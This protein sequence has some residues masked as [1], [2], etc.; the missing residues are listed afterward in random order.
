MALDF[1]SNPVNGQT[2]GN[3]YYDSD[4]GIWRSLYRPTVP[5]ILESPTINNA[6]ITTT[7]TNATT[8][9][10]TVKGAS[11]QSS[12]LQEWKNSSGT[13]LTSISSSGDLTATN[14]TITNLILNRTNSVEEGG[15]INFNRASDN[16]NHW[17]IDVFGSTSTPSLRF[18][19]STQTNMQ[20]D[21][22]GRVT[23]PFQPA[24]YAQP[25]SNNNASNS[26]GVFPSTLANTGNHYS[27]STGRFTAPVAGVYMFEAAAMPQAN[28]TVEFY[29]FRKNGAKVGTWTYAINGDQILNSTII[30]SLAANDY[31]DLFFVSDGYEY[32]FTYFSGH[33]IG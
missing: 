10:L 32:L 4:K 14:A 28:T 3:Y 25:T 6:V 2:Y 30:L 17:F 12:N 33:L 18:I 8:V 29:R 11:S 20:I 22:G 24:F 15:Q 13:T 5:N 23:M 21:S 27:T 19:A 7:A 16:A 1:P 9:P 26:V 31:V